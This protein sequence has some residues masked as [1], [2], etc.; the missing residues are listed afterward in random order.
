MAVRD[1]VYV[2]DDSEFLH[3]ASDPVDPEVVSSDEIQTLIDDMFDTKKS[4]NGVGISAV[5]IGVH[6]NIIIV[7][8]PEGSQAFINPEITKFSDDKV[9]VEEGC[10]SIPD[11]FGKV[12][13]SRSVVVK[14]LTR[15]GDEIELKAQG[16]PAVIFQHEIDHTNGILFTDPQ[17]LITYTSGQNK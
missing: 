2:K 4:A 10:L 6:K 12:E 14:A 3:T 16:M 17:R 8:L 7:E 9:I 1:L 13:R 5:Q 15:K 11:V